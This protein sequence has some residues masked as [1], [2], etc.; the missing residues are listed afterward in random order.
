ML[1]VPPWGH[2]VR[3]SCSVAA[4]QCRSDSLLGICASIRALH[5][6]A[7]LWVL[8]IISL[9]LTFY[10]VPL[11]PALLLLTA[12]VL[13][14]DRPD[15]QILMRTLRRLRWLLLATL[16]LHA[17]LTPGP[18]LF[19]EVG[20]L[21]PAREGLQEGLLRSLALLFMAFWA[22]WL[23]HGVAPARMAQAIAHLLQPF[24]RLGFPVTRLASRLS[25]SLAA[26]DA[27]GARA[28]SLR[29]S[30]A[31]ERKPIGLRAGLQLR[32][33]VLLRLFEEIEKVLPA[34]RPEPEMP[35]PALAWR[36]LLMLLLV[37]GL[38]GFALL[39]DGL[40]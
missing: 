34:E 21:S 39:I 40:Q 12:L 18:L 20:V 8:I 17:Y 5:P 37:I 13:F 6:L 22:I 36:D 33:E 23:M 1:L 30:L 38:M 19:P 32:A 31:G 11:L 7:R 15:R 10:L 2:A 9:A 26:V 25:M 3:L 16:L 35:L 28:R 4:G 14:C 24:G 27:M 29:A